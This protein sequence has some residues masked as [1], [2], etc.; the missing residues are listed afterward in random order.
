MKLRWFHCSS[1]VPV[2]TPP[3][4]SN[5]FPQ[6]KFHL[7]LFYFQLYFI[8][9]CRVVRLHP[10]RAKVTNTETMENVTLSTMFQSCIKSG[11]T[12]WLVKKDIFISWT[13]ALQD[14]P[15]VMWLV[16]KTCIFLWPDFSCSL[17]GLRLLW[18]TDLANYLRQAHI[19]VAF[20]CDQ[21][22]QS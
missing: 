1:P 18:N 17:T 20:F 21:A 8:I 16:H 14:G 9:D 6:L 19:W 13:T 5:T 10:R 4:P 15:S 11:K 2:I 12:Q 7:S 22:V 3:L